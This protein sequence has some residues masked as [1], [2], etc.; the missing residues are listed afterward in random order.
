[1][2][3]H[4]TTPQTYALVFAA[5][6]ALTI[7]TILLARVDLGVLHAAVGLAIAATNATLIVLFFMHLL[8][9]AR[10][11]WLVALSSLMWLAILLSLTLTDYLSRG[12][13]LEK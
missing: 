13:V 12:W 4:K 7:A 9:S 10:V 5:L 8:Q 2:A 11:T 6:I 1:M 3:E